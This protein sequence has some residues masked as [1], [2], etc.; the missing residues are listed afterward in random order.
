MLF[1]DLVGFTSYSEGRDAEDVRELLSRYFDTAKRL[2][3]LYGGTIEKFIGDAV[4]AVWGTPVAQE[5]DAERAVRAALDLTAAVTELGAECGVPQLRARAGVLTG[6]AAVTLGADSQGMVAGDLVNTASRIQSAAQPGTVLVGEATRRT[7]EAAV[8]YEEAGVHEMKGKTE[9]VPLWRATRVVA[10]RGGA[11][12]S[13]GLEPPFV[14]RD[15]ELRLV[16][17]L[18]HASAEESRAHLASIIGIGGIGKSR[19]AWEFEKYLDGL[20]DLFLWHRGRCLAYGEGVTYWALAEMVRMRARISEGESQASAV[21]KLHGV[22]EEYVKDPG[23][24]EWVEP[25][26]AHLLGLEERTARDAEDLFSAWRL[27]VER[28][29]EERPVVL[30]FEDMQW[31]DQSL[32]EFVDYLMTWSKNHALFVIVLA[33]PEFVEKH[34]N[35]GSGRRGST[36]LYL[37]PLS[38]DAMEALLGGLVPGLPGS[39]RSKILERAEGVPLYAVET[40]RMLLDRGLLVQEGAVYRP[41]GPVED[42]QVPET[43]QALI[44]AR[45]DALDPAERRLLQDAAVVG[46]T[47]TK[48]ALTALSGSSEN[49]V[50][51]LLASLRR[52]EF[53]SIQADPRSPEHGQ[54]GFLQDLVRRV[55]YETLARKDRKARHLAAAAH[56]EREWGADAE[57]VVEVVASHYLEAYQAAP[58][59]ADADEIKAKA[60]DALTNAGQRAASLAAYEEAR[61]YFVQAIELTDDPLVSAALHERAGDMARTGGRPPEAVEHYESSIEL[62]R[63]AGKTHAVARVSAA[64]GDALRELGRIPE[65][66]EHL[67]AAFLVLSSEEPDADLATLAHALG[68]L[69]F[70]V[71]N[72]D[73]SVQRTELALT[74]AEKLQLPELFAHALNTKSLALQTYGRPEEALVLLRHSLQV[75]L[76]DDLYE[77]A[78]RSL[79]NIG[80]QMNE[81]DRHEEELEA[82]DKLIELARKA[83]NRLWE[84]RGVAGQIGPLFN[85]G[86]WDEALDLA[87]TLARDADTRILRTLTVDMTYEAQ[88]HALRGD[89]QAARRWI[90]QYVFMGESE[91]VQES[92]AYG[93]ARAWVL[94]T[95]GTFDE[96]L[97]LADRMYERARDGL[98]VRAPATKEALTAWFAAAFALKDAS[99]IERRLAEIDALRPGEITPSLAAQRSRLGARLAVL[100]GEI[101]GVDAG[102]KEALASFR[103]LPLPLWVGIVLLEYGEWLASQGR[104]AEASQ[105]LAE[106]RD[107][108]E[109]LGARPFIERLDG[110]TGVTD[111]VTTG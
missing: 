52:K 32:I 20:L 18:F 41:T 88:I 78:S 94:F 3:A 5:D 56:L 80:A 100:R 108:F 81:R 46:K 2:V 6:E 48:A 57:E 67:N 25:R 91:D 64:Y 38:P 75:A 101:E 77:A 61:R 66:L 99:G 30:V 58:D 110:L 84:L 11:Q 19:L 7:T 17:E 28:M 82:G 1:A 13:A 22:I 60:R 36:T 105:L 68:R 31:A 95:E 86:R 104:E 44:A 29:T 21:T 42:L 96:C 70:F 55:A 4:M 79:N 73:E 43:L 109:S 15:R 59:A 71:G 35:W 106:A 9:P 103:T 16:K 98:G 76:D 14:G 12:K 40:V 87:Q 53:L 97:K 83:G 102:F 69:N 10:G 74:L 34:P 49:E 39:L 62:F 65:A 107:V 23:E 26:L 8:V 93:V 47:F 111:R 33:R 24:R 27:F 92:S 85:L 90:E 50:E 63:E 89:I 54:H 37:E 72:L 51:D 45:L